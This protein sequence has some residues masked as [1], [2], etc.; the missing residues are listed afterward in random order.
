[1]G[2][3]TTDKDVIFRCNTITQKDN[4]MDDFN[5]GHITS[6]EA[7]ILMDS[8]NDYFNGKYDDF[9]GRFYSDI[10]LYIPVTVLKML[11][12]WLI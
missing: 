9:K 7:E 1:M 2:I 8:L 5:A 12:Y 3:E 4:H 11:S 6:E 10:C